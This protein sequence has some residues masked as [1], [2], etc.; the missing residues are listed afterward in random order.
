MNKS[1]KFDLK[2]W[3]KEMELTQKEAATKLG[4]SLRTYKYYEQGAEHSKMLILA[5]TLLKKKR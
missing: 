3:R 1:S 4:V 2:Q 5:C